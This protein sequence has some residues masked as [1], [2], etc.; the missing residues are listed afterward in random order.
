MRVYGASPLYNYVELVFRSKRL[1]IASVLLATVATVAVAVSRAKS[2]NASALI[3]L[4]GSSQTGPQNIDK[5]DKAARGSIQFKLNVLNIVLKDPNFLKKAFK[6]GGLQG[7]MN[8]EQ[9]DQFCKDARA[10]M[11]YGAGENI[12]EISCR[13]KDATAEKII[14]AFYSAYA[15]RV[16]DQE[17]VLSQNETKLLRK[18]L[19]EY[20]TKVQTLEKKVVAYQ[21]NKLEDQ[22][23]DPSGASTSYQAQ[24][25]LV[26]NYETRMMMSNLQLNRI[27]FELANTPKTIIDAQQLED[28]H[29]SPQYQLLEQQKAALESQKETLLLTKT[30]SHPDVVKI[31]KL[32]SAVIARMEKFDA[33]EKAK[34][35]GTKRPLTTNVALNPTWQTLDGRRADMEI[36]LRGMTVELENARK[37]LLVAQNKARSAPQQ[38]YDFRWMTRN[39]NLYSAIR[40]NLNGKLESAIMEE[41]RDRELSL[42]QI[43]MM[44]EPRAEPEVVGA[45]SLIFFAAGPIIGLIIAFGFSLL[46][47]SLDHSLRTP[48]EVEKY[49]GKPVLA[50]LPR[51]D[52]PKVKARP[53][54]GGGGEA[55]PT[56]PS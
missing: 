53:Q 46:A 17:T 40:E 6:E 33:D 15:N 21:K 39:L 27:K 16:L 51:M 5:D 36:M 12:L 18:L 23:S 35:K 9:F 20:T 22:L 3:L 44:V 32:L 29:R 45:K 30:E 56:L 8:D 34:P 14:N 49:L 4:S 13:W 50:V 38:V 31:Q 48:I 25:Q 28:P 7:N 1:F 19:D 47:E 2:Y 42:A 11:T 43:T 37:Q 41:K 55:R 24:Q 26:K 10:A 52:T 54:L